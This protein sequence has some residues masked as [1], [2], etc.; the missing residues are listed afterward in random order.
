MTV[1][2]WM[3]VAAICFFCTSTFCCVLLV[4]VWYCYECREQSPAEQP[5]LVLA[6]TSDEEEYSLGLPPHNH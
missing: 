4:Y 2:V 5:E 3:I 1:A 6:H